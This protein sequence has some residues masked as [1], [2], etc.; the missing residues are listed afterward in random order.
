MRTG[1]EVCRLLSWRSMNSR[2]V[3]RRAKLVVRCLWICAVL[4]DVP[5]DL[6]LHALHCNHE[7]RAAIFLRLVDIGTEF[8]NQVLYH[9]QL[10]LLGCDVQWSTPPIVCSLG[11]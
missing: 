8:L 3:R 2:E 4:E 5:H 10:S 11:V 9:F 1:L 6:V 7:G